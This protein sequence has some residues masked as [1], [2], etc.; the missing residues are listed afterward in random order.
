MNLVNKHDDILRGI[1]I[2][3]VITTC[4]SNLPKEDINEK[5]VKDEF[6]NI[7][8]M[9]IEDANFEINDKM[10]FILKELDV[11]SKKD[12]ASRMAYQSSR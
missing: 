11:K 10:E 1:T 6:K 4:Y 12:K 7:L 9:A 2:E 5:T 3:D 8:N